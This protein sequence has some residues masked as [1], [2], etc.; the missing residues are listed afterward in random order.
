MGLQD[1]LD[2]AALDP[3]TASGQ[4]LGDQG[5]F[6]NLRS[7]PQRLDQNLHGLL[8]SGRPQSLGD[9]PERLFSSLHLLRGALG[10]GAQVKVEALERLPSYP[11]FPD[12]AQ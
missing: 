8:G 4:S 5:R 3:H 12:Q 6:W 9:H 7:G 1:L 2:V 11:P 10:I